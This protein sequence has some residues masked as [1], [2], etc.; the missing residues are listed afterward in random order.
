MVVIPSLSRN[1]VV[2]RKVGGV[3]L[4]TTL[5]VF[6]VVP[7][8]FAG[9]KHRV[10][11]DSSLVPLDTAL[12]SNDLATAQSLAASV[13][14]QAANVLVPADPTI[15]IDPAV[16]TT[17]TVALGQCKTAYEIAGC[18]YRHADLADAKQ[19]ATTATAVDSLSDPYARRAMVLLGNIAYA[20]DQDG[21]AAT[22]FL[23]VIVRPNLYLEQASAYAGLLDVLMY[24]KQDDQVVQW[25]QNGQ[26]Q[27]A[28]GGDLQLA[29]LHDAAQAL[30]RRN[31]PLWRQLDQQIVDLFPTNTPSRLQALRELASNARKFERWAE[32]ETNYAALCALPLPTAPEAVDTWFLLAE[33]QAKQGEDVTATLRNLTAVCDGFTDTEDCDYGTYRLGKFYEQ[34]G[35]NALASATYAA[36]A[37]GGSVSTWAGAALHELGALTEKQGDLPGAL[38]LYLEYPQRF[39][40]NE[41]FVVESYSSAL[42]VAAALGDTNS[43]NFVYGAITNNM[44]AIQDYNVMLNL[45]RYFL[46]QNNKPLARSFLERGLTLAQRALTSTTDPAQRALI[47]FRILRR[48]TDFGQYQRM[49]DYLGANAAE[50]PGPSA[51]PNSD[52][53]HLQCYAYQAIALH[54]SGDAPGAEALFTGLLDRAQGN[55]ELEGKF[56]EDLAHLYEQQSSDNPAAFQ[57]FEWVARKYP[58]HQWANFGRLELAVQAFNS[59]SFTN[60]LKLTDDITN[61]LPQTS[62]MAWIQKTYWGAVYLRG[63]CLQA[64]GQT[65][66]GAALKQLAASQC[67]ALTIQTRLRL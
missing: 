61:G 46:L 51:D 30:K 7:P 59:G 3:A 11:L 25:V 62:K 48:M 5:A 4:V 13:Y 38:Q 9:S 34:Q 44:A 20:M 14:Q 23:S 64:Q 60:A 31:H 65:Q 67:P 42:N 39:P 37:S 53:N 54:W 55:A 8:A 29:F 26:A 47:Q 57:L 49:L 40:Q 15:I 12:Q 50:F 6:L 1:L 33:C 63:C 36:L 52:D 32:A 58:S 18:F 45:G 66:D 41:G 24:Q 2:S 56:G 16:V 22:N 19:W 10:R 27:F 17:Q 21:L 35:R 43:A 28:G